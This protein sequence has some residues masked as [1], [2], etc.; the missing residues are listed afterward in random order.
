MNKS[1]LKNFAI[2]ARLEL[3]QR[4]ADRAALYG[5]DEAKSKTRTIAS[6]ETFHKLDGAVLTDTEIRQRN[7]LI[8][9]V[10]R[11]GYRP[12]M[13]EAAY[14]WFNRF[15]AIK[16]MQEHLLLPVLQRVLPDSPGVLPQVLREAQDV[17]LPG[18]NPAAVLALLDANQTDELYKLLLIALC[19]ALSDPLPGMFEK[20]SQTSELLFPD[21][22]L[23]AESVLGELAKLD[24]DIWADIQV[25]GWLYQYY[26][27]QLKD[28]T[29]ELLK[30]NV[31][32]TKDRI[33]AATQLFTPEWIVRYMVENSL[34]RLWQE[35]HHDKNLRMKWRY[36]MDE[37]PQE[38]EVAA[39][40]A[41]LR[42]GYAALQPEQLTVL[43]PCMGSGHILVYAFDVLMDIYRSVGYTDRDAVQSIMENN[44]YGLDIDDRAAQLAYFALMMKACEYDRR[45]LRRGVQPHVCAIAESVPVDEHLL[46]VFGTEKPLARQLLRTF[47]NAKEYGNLLSVDMTQDE[48][49]RLSSRV[50]EL[51]SSSQNSLLAMADSAQ[52]VA[53]VKPLLQQSQILA[54]KYDSVITNPPY[55]GGSGMNE[56]LSRFVKENY[57]D[58]KSDLFACFIERGNTMVKTNGLNCMVTMQS[59]MFLSSFEKMRCHILKTKDI[60]CL[61]HMENMVLGIAFGTA[62]TIFKNAHT[63]GYKGTYNQI[64]LCDIEN[65]VPKTFPVSENRFSQVSTDNFSKIPGAPVAYWVSERFLQSFVTGIMLGKIADSKQGLA[66]SDNDKFVRFWYEPSFCK[67]TLHAHD[68]T[69]AVKLNAKWVPYNKGGNFRK[70]YGNNEFVV[71]WEN[72]G[73]EIKHLYDKNGKL[74]SRPQNTQYYFRESGSWSLI[75]SSVAAFRYKP[76]GHIFDVAG[77]SFFSDDNLYFLL[78]LC[79]SVYTM[80]VLA[81]VAP[82]INYQCGDIANIPVKL[83]LKENVEKKVS[84]NILLSRNDWDSFETSWDFKKHPMI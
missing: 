43:D 38:P 70:W 24:A 27:T 36:Y 23:K 79:N 64:K 57:P 15:I 22:L 56:N 59:W 32:I 82:T 37:A 12:A 25:I 1:D 69:E 33:G 60:V 61:M 4:V 68:A 74:R 66:T 42:R 20:I 28:E 19:N 10:Y 14:T 50:D 9:R 3:L 83:V 63:H 13:E 46:D 62:V 51:E 84:D 7:A 2:R 58:S 80:Q 72:N 45:F 75:S 29:F 49:R 67:L 11:L 54:C 30:K 73:Y 78:G 52:S 34:G 81:I 71:N 77:M 17:S 55:M 65:E 5:V 40:L 47:S 6:S 18:V 39:Q 26:N 44:L 31:K 41:E 76:Y 8:A 16:Y 21:A 53:A 35:G 48:L